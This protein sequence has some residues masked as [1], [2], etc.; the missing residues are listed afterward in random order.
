M[1][2]PKERGIGHNLLI[3][4][5]VVWLVSWFVPVVREQQWFGAAVTEPRPATVTAPAAEAALDA[6]DWLP[7]WGACRYAWDLLVGDAPSDREA[8]R[9]RVLGATC[10]DNL[11]MLAAFVV[12]ATGRKR[13]LVGLLL[14]VAGGHAAGWLY[15]TERPQFEGLRAGYYLWLASFVLVGFGALLQPPKGK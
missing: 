5:V 11:V 4:G 6:P 1:G 15:L 3:A 14:L 10:L 13:V 8:W 12:F 9:S 2:K 7:G